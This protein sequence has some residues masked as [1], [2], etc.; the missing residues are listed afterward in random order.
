MSAA[1]YD[2]EQPYDIEETDFGYTLIRFS[3]DATALSVMEEFNE[4]YDATPISSA[5]FPGIDSHFKM[6]L[7]NKSGRFSGAVYLG[8]D[9]I[10]A[11]EGAG[12]N[13]KKTA[14]DVLE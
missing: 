2:L 3:D 8:T 6:G 13:L 5:R 14:E 12:E 4:R 11:T 10:L 1:E 7:L 9:T